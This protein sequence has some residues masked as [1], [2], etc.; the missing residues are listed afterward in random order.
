MSFPR[1]FPQLNT[2]RLLL[3]RIVPEDKDLLY[4]IYTEADTANVF[5]TD[6]QSGIDQMDIIMNGFKQTYE[7]KEGIYWAIT[8]RENDDLIGTCGYEHLEVNSHGDISFSIPQKYWKKGITQESLELIIEYGFEFL[9]L[10]EIKAH[11][12]LANVVTRRL[13]EKLKFKIDEAEENAVH[14]KLDKSTWTSKY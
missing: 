3:R 12:T 2:E 6:D 13:F 4:K 8:L 1:V 5:F 10:N 9:G 11:T 14:Y 7:N